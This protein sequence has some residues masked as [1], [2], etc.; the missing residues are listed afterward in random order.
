MKVASCQIVKSIDYWTK[1]ASW[2]KKYFEQ[3]DRTRKYFYSDL[4]EQRW[5]K[6]YGE[7]N[8]EHLLARQ[9]SSSSLRR[10]QAQLGSV[11]P[12]SATP[13]DQKSRE[14]K[15]APYKH[16][17][18][19][20][21]LASKNSF[22]DKDEVGII[23]ESKE[24]CR[25]LLETDQE[26]PE[27]SLFRDDLFEDTCREIQDRNEAKVI[28]DIARLIV[29]SVRHL[30]IR[31]AKQLK[32]LTESV[33]EGWINAIPVT[34]TRPQ[35]DYAIGFDRSAF[36]TEH[37]NKLEPFF[38]DFTKTSYF[39][40]TYYMYLPF[41]TCEV[42]CGAAA[43]DIADRQNA[44]SMTLAVRGVV[45]M[46]K[47]VGREKEIDREILAFSISHDDQMVRIY[48]HYPVINGDKTAIYRWPIRNF[49]F[50]GL[51]GKDKWTAQK[52]TRNMYSIWVP[53]H[54]TRLCS[55]MDEVPPDIDFGV[56]PLSEATGLSQV[57][58]SHHLSQS[59]TASASPLQEDDG[60]AQDVTPNTSFSQ[61]AVAKKARKRRAAE[62]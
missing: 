27:D 11:V 61:P 29:P 3:D 2:P 42:K 8:M 46:F 38:G 24:L 15:S 52:F 51:E 19:R 20:T 57:L 32:I 21:E 60:Q 10:T 37:L 45:E 5:F 41:F 14:E 59:N 40:A 62:H 50:T 30:A 56:P 36:T 12:S 33:N 4:E 58:D 35:P 54:L 49:S 43:L 53:G 28:Q 34:K 7:P 26:I 18:Y 48:G 13:S 44:H 16:P 47:L 25:K 1:T 39:K 31:G 23:Q 17:A 22:M 55:V 6:E 9:K